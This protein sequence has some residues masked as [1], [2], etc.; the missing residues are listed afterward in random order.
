MV[1]KS[2]DDELPVFELKKWNGVALWS[3]DTDYDNCAICRTHIM[4]KCIECAP[5]ANSEEAE[6]CVSAWGQCGHA[7][8]YHCIQ[9]WLKTRPVCPLD[10][11]DWVFDKIGIESEK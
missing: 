2:N 6:K 5:I 11:K 9:K 3:W 10:N 1:S 4:E 8:H 7:F